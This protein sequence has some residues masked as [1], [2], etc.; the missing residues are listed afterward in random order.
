[1]VNL[2]R[3]NSVSFKEQVVH[4]YNRPVLTICDANPGLALYYI[5]YARTAMEYDGLFAELVCSVL[6]KALHIQTPDVALVEIG[7][8]PTINIEF[9]YPK[10]LESGMIA[11]GSRKV[12]NV[13]ELNQQTAI[14]NKHDFNRFRSPVDIFKIALFDLW[15]AN[16]DRRESNFNILIQ[17]NDLKDI[18]AFDHFEAFR[19]HSLSSRSENE[20][21]IHSGLMGSNFCYNLVN[22]LSV[23][24][25]KNATN[26]FFHKAEQLDIDKILNE[27]FNQLPESW[28][29]QQKTV[30]S[31]HKLLTDSVRLDNIA[32]EADIAINSIAVEKS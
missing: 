21:N 31:I 1:M 19:M 29:V 17:N 25:L 12:N 22:Y 3:V 24:E 4:T 2:N 16:A 6:A 27:L 9:E 10:K 15:I 7:D 20:I 28:S 26:E 23:N 8:H 11:F 30:N 5:K 14:K 18:Y 32:Q 13:I